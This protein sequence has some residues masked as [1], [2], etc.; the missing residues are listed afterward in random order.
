MPTKLMGQT[1][2]MLDYKM[3]VY[4]DDYLSEQGG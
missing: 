4:V 2:K 3:P 1:D